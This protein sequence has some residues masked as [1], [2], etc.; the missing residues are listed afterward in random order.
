MGRLKNASAYWHV[1]RASA[2]EDRAN[3]WRIGGSVFL[4]IARMIMLAAIYRV[5]YATAGGQK[6][7]LPFANSLWS[8]G[9]YFALIIGLGMRNV[10]K[11]VD[12]D[13]K[14]GSVEGS[15]IKPLD[16][17]L[18]KVVT[19][20]G[21][22]ILESILLAVSFA[23]TLT[24]LVGLPDMGFV[25]PEFA[26]GYVLIMLL[27]IV[28][29]STLYM[30]VGLTAFW[31]NDAMPT[32]RIIDK[33]VLIFGGAFVPIALLPDAVQAVVRYSPFGVYAASTQLFNPGLASHLLPTIISS[34]AWT[35]LTV[36]FCNWVWRRAERRIEVNGG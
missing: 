36:L 15:L 21:K 12:Q 35:V 18:T 27:A 31:L 14:S 20:L 6:A 7:S 23:I 8:I 9:L 2:R 16:W 32:Y 34:L 25:T 5:A 1:M 33:V 11:L 10:F 4:G 17:R 28:S 22:N 24:V 26:A 30:V 19:L 3:P 29:S 13:I